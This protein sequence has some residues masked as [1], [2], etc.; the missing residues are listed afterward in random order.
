VDER[1]EE[2]RVEIKEG[3]MEEDFPRGDLV[4]YYSAFS[5]ME[6]PYGVPLKCGS[7]GECSI[8]K[9]FPITIPQTVFP[10]LVSMWKN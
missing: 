4:S 10:G 6:V 3:I 7:S 8:E 9:I 1:T 2:R 5:G